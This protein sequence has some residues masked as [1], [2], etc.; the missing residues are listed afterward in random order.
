MEKLPEKQEGF[1]L[2]KSPIREAYIILGATTPLE[3][4]K[5]YT[6][7]DQLLFIS[8]KWDYDEKDQIPNRIKDILENADQIGLTEEEKE[9]RSEILWFWYHHAISCANWKRDK[10]KM[11]LFSEKAL[12]YQDNNP[13]ILTRTMFF[14]A[15]DQIEKAEE[16]VVSKIEDPD[17]DTATEIIA[18]YKKNG[19]F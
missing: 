1:D 15:H 11:K 17:H 8:R 13:N 6:E 18:N 9:W 16:W 4:N 19:F 2:K 3:L 10:E 14:L 7:Q 12:E 5:L